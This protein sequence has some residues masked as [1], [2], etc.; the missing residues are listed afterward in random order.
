MAV[1]SICGAQRGAGTDGWK[2]GG[3][4]EE[5]WVRGQGTR[6]PHGRKK[7]PIVVPD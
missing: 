5:A 1:P 2:R 3:G 6:V 4:D 7:D